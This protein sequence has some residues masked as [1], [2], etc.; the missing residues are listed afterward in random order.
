MS[1]D[2]RK[3]IIDALRFGNTK[4]EIADSLLVAGWDL[5][6]IQSAFVDVG[7][8]VNPL[9]AKKTSGFKKAF[10]ATSF[11]V[12][13]LTASTAYL[14]N[15]RIDLS[16]T[17]ELAVQD[18]YTELTESQISFSDAGEM[19]FPDEQ[20]FITQKNEYVASGTDFIE[21]D[22]RKMEITLFDNGASIGTVAVLS[23]GKEGSWW[24]TPTGNYKVLGKTP[25]GY[26]SI[27]NVWMP[28]SIQFYG[29]YLIHGWPHYDD[30]T[31]VRKGYSGGCIRLSDDDART[32]Y[33]FVN[34]STPI[35]VLEDKERH[36]FGVLT[37]RVTDAPIDGI[38]AKA[39][40]ITDIS[41]GNVLL[42][43]N[44]E[45]VMPIASLTK[46]MTAIVAHEVIYLGKSIT[47]SERMLAN[48]AQAF[49][50]VVSKRYLGLDLLYP[51]LMQ[52]SNDSANVLASFI[53][54]NSFMRNMNNK[55]ASLDMNNTT[56]V[57]PSG[58]GAQNISTTEDVAKM[59]QYIYFNRNFLFDIGRGVEFKNIGSIN[60]G[61]TVNISDLKNFNEFV[62]RPDLIG[63]KNGQTTAAR[64]TMATVWNIKTKSGDVP[65]SIVVLGSED[66]EADTD[67]LIKWV[68]K[69]YE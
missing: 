20:K 15:D 53:G 62:D 11:A 43:K 1:P 51:L 45:D 66:R 3:Y 46:L 8:S 24:E 23:K 2:I 12:V 63:V 34:N 26:S 33:N 58:I 25:N 37:Q 61:R 59:L 44:A 47:V 18:F 69:N 4:E 65:V 38:D 49:H 39:F 14:W 68:K 54:N 48:V 64:E 52:S 9:G 21:V 41:T 28:Y 30:G 40:L 67:V 60:L 32:V 17:N 19:V 10:I 35:L 42:E 57:D 13:I 6:D 22:L 56:F 31:P 29:N 5:N 16:K 36:D 55:A 7:I 27:G 50:P